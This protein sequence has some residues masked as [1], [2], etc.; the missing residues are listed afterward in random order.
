MIEIQLRFKNSVLKTIETDRD[1]ITIG[2]KRNNTIEIDNL[3]VSNKHARIIKHADTYFIEDL[4]STNCT[5]LNDQKV[6]KAPLRDK[7]IITIGK[8]T[9]VINFIQEKPDNDM[10]DPTYAV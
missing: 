8:H 4:N 1:E 7:D 3:Q 2:R 10:S 5:F 6:T 9:L